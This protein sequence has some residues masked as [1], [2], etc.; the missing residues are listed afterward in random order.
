MTIHAE[1]PGNRANFSHNPKKEQLNKPLGGRAVGAAV[2]AGKIERGYGALQLPPSAEKLVLS[3]RGVIGARFKEAQDTATERLT[4][5]ALVRRAFTLQSNRLEQP[6]R[7]DWTT[8]QLTS[9]LIAKAVLFSPVA[10]EAQ[11]TGNKRQLAEFNDMFMECA[12]CISPSAAKAFVPMMKSEINNFSRQAGVNPDITADNN[13]EKMMAG[14]AA[15]VA[16]ARAL[17]TDPS[18]KIVAP[19]VDLDLQGVDLTVTREDTH[20]L[21]MDLKRSRPF[22]TKLDEMMSRGRMSREDYEDGIRYGYTFTGNN[23]TDKLPQYVV[24]AGRFGTL[25]GFDYDAKGQEEAVATVHDILDYHYG[26]S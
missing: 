15:E 19:G 25:D 10:S 23:R 5:P 24:D 4:R 6:D 22:I 11:R 16:T 20:S 18:L 12:T 21:H 8:S 3:T 14:L 26:N 17:G 2:R 9:E 7:D 13:L 1:R